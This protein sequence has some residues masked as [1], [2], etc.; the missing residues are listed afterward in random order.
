MNRENLILSPTGR[1]V[2]KVGDMAWQQFESGGY[3]VSI[4][5]DSS[6]TECEPIMAIWSAGSA[7]GGVFGICLSSIGKYADP[8]GNPNPQAFVECLRALPTLGRAQ[9]DIEVYALLDVILRHTP[10]LIRCPV[11]PPAMRMA[12]AGDPLLEVTYKSEDGKTLSES[13]I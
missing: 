12:E 3:K 8:S 5:W 4:E 10:D 6:A 13:L 1:Q 2:T 9:I 11:Q 7:D